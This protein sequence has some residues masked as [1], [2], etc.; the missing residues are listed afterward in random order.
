MENKNIEIIENDVIKQLQTLSDDSNFKE[1]EKIINNNSKI[2]KKWNQEASQKIIKKLSTDKIVDLYHRFKENFTV[3]LS[4]FLVNYRLDMMQDNFDTP[5]MPRYFLMASCA[6][7]DISLHKMLKIDCINLNPYLKHMDKLYADKDGVGILFSKCKYDVF[8]SK[9]PYLNE[10]K[11]NQ[12]EQLLMCSTSLSKSEKLAIIRNIKNLDLFQIRE[13][14]NIFKSEVE[15]FSKL[16]IKTLISLVSNS[17]NCHIE[18]REVQEEVYK[19]KEISLLITKDEMF[20]STN[21]FFTP[22]SIQAY[23]SKSVIGQDSALK[24]ISTTIYYHIKSLNHKNKFY[25]S[26]IYGAHNYLK[27]SNISPILLAGATGSGKT[28][29]VQEASEFAKVNFF[30]IDAST[31]VTTGIVG[32]SV[33]NIGK[34]LLRQTNYDIEKAQTSILFFDECDK[35]LHKDSGMAVLSQLLRLSEGANLS[36]NISNYDYDSE[37]FKDI[38]S[39]STNKMLIIFAGSF[40]D[41]IDK[42]TVGFNSKANKSLSKSDIK[43]SGLPKEFIG[44]LKQMIVLNKLSKDDY[45]NILTN[46]TSSPLNDYISKLKINGNDLVVD[47][48]LLVKITNL[49][50]KSDYGVRTIFSILQNLFEDLLFISPQYKDHEFHLTLDDLNTIGGLGNG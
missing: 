17:K 1:I 3:D 40:Q 31:L 15:Q 41:L 4:Q 20:D 27:C 44:R 32:D 23:L 49:A 48:E 16:S 29:I 36:I 33:D 11:S 14:I 37:K 35:L 45:Y 34:D 21:N 13:L 25:E 50:S 28:M 5:V 30:H 26:K 39:I 22:K 9:V 46:S 18:W 43:K 6:L 2:I 47:D 7:L 10:E 12:F 38:K 19:E 42:T 8:Q 24:S